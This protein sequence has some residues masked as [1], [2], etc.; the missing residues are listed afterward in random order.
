MVEMGIP[1]VTTSGN[2]S[3]EPICID[4]HEAL[5]RLGGIAEIFLVHNRPIV[6]HVD[7]SIVRVTMGRE[8]VL[9]R[10][11]GYAPL[12]IH[13]KEPMP[14]LLAVGAHLKN[15]VAISV[16][17]EIFVSQHI[18]DLETAQAFDAF[19]RVIENFEHLYDVQP[20]SVA[21]DS[22]PDYLSTKLAQQYG[23]SAVSVQHHFAHVVSCMTESDLTG[24]VLGVAWDGTGYGLDGT[25]WGGEFLHVTERSFLRVGH[26]RRSRLPGSEKAIKEPRR[27]A[28][29]LLYE[30]LGDEIFE[31]KEL[32][33]VQAFSSQELEILQT[34]LKKK[35]NSPLTSSAGRLFDAMASIVGIRQKTS[36]EGQA[37]MELEFALDGVETDE[38]YPV[39]ILDC[40]LLAGEPFQLNPKSQI[41]KPNSVYVIDW[42]PMLQ[43]ILNDVSCRIP[44]GKISAKFHNTLVEAIVVIAYRIGEERVVLTGGCFQNRYLTERAIHRLRSENFRP[45]WH[46]RIP[47]NDGGIALGQVIAA[48]QFQDSKSNLKIK[49]RI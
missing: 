7:D 17:R 41:P 6:Q 16:D 22:H 33:P 38:K 26:F 15:T 24:P 25:I 37:A 45:Y 4:E 5:K 28:I 34:M 39:Q 31:M 21:C 44:V 46:Q 43:G 13:L 49:S 10:A 48:H 47:P 2:L 8:L 1:V 27:T 3:D 19:R 14:S 42:E 23:V 9:R 11:R 32:A 36:F 18:G 12:P 40:G 35:I 30:L 29:G 20:T